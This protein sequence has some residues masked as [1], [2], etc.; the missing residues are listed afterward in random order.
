[1]D[2]KLLSFTDY[3]DKDSETKNL[4]IQELEKEYVRG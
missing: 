2:I 4:L 1:M 3:F